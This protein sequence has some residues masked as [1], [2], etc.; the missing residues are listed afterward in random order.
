MSRP[1][2]AEVASVERDDRL[3]PH[4]FRERYHRGIC[5]TQR[6]VPVLPHERCDSW[7]VVRLRRPD[8]E[9]LKSGEEPRLPF[10]P[11]LPCDQVRRLGHAQ[12][13]NDQVEPRSTEDG[14]ARGMVRILQVSGRYQWPAIHDRDQGRPPSVWQGSH[15]G[16]QH[17]AVRRSHQPR[18]TGSPVACEL[19][20]RA[21]RPQSRAQSW[22]RK[23]AAAV[24]PVPPLRRSPPAS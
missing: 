10:W 17:G 12:C 20:P 21:A 19:S 16:Q 22:K 3:R 4:P 24:L 23:R 13:R 8:I 6:E 11:E 7:P 1:N 15:P 14:K 18:Q 2:C 9:W 5:P